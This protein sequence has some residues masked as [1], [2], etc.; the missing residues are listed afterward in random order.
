MVIY[1][2]CDIYPAAM[3]YPAENTRTQGIRLWIEI[4]DLFSISS[5][6]WVSSRWCAQGH[7]SARARLSA[8][9]VSPL[10]H[11]KNYIRYKLKHNQEWNKVN[12]QVSF[13]AGAWFCQIRCFKLY[14]GSLPH[15]S[16]AQQVNATAAWTFFSSCSDQNIRNDKEA[17]IFKQR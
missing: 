5:S 10:I 2:A 13:F 3:N 12:K 1:W 16:H 6:I 9:L 4:K 7:T 11:S 15:C 17:W 8:S 14:Q